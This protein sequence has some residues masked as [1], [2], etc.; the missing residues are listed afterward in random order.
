MTFMRRL[1]GLGER[2]AD[3]KIEEGAAVDRLLGGSV[4][5]KGDKVE[6]WDGQDR[7]A[8]GSFVKYVPDDFLPAAQVEVEKVFVRTSYYKVG[9]T[10]TFSK[11][12]LRP[13]KK[14]VK[15][16]SVTDRLRSLLSE[17]DDY[18]D[19]YHFT[20]EDG[21]MFVL[22]KMG[23]KF[24]VATAGATADDDMADLYSRSVRKAA[25]M[26]DAVKIIK[27]MVR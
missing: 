17:S 14:G 20:N 27:K 21:G 19:G 26:A 22:Q 13:A 10:G 4:F 1:A 3:R 8:M 6:I 18:E 23:N 24:V 5:R 2:Y 25:S 11:T 7:I 12:M 15:E 9:E 16:S